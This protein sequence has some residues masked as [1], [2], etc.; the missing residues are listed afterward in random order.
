[1]DVAINTGYGDYKKTLFVKVNM[2]GE[3]GA[4]IADYLTTGTLIATVGELST[5]A[6]QT[7]DGE[8]R[9]DLIVDVR[10]IQILKSKDAASGPVANEGAESPGIDNITF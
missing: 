1:M 7:R 3:N 10:G 8:N 2:W 9:I 4:K 6:W 5:N